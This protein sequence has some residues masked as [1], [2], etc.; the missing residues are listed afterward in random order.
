[1]EVTG[2]LACGGLRFSLMRKRMRQTFKQDFVP[3]VFELPIDKKYS[4]LSSSNAAFTF[5]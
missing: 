5:R 3:H 4:W 1:M 2:K